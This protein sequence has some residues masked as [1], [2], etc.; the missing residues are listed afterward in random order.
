MRRL[1]LIGAAG[2]ERA[3]DLLRAAA[4]LATIRLTPP[5]I[6]KIRRE[7]GMTVESIADFYEQT[8]GGR[9]IRERGRE[10]GRD[11]GLHE[12]R[13]EGR[14]ESL[15]GLLQERFGD[16]PR[17]ATVAHRLARTAELPVALRAVLAAA[18]LDDLCRPDDV[19]QPHNKDRADDVHQP[20][21]KDRP[22]EP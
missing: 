19:H 1:L 15:A 8:E 16:D 11:E 14:E 12:G 21:N 10:E 4:D 13:D 20:H 22:G 18:S 17:V 2:G 7:V 3:A 6:E 5:T 9:L